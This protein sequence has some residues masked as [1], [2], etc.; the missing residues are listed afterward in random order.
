[1]SSIVHAYLSTTP[2]AILFI[3]FLISANR[4]PAVLRDAIDNDEEIN[5]I[6]L[7]DM[8]HTI[9]GML[10]FYSFLVIYLSFFV[11]RRRAL[12]KKF[13]K[14]DG[15][16]ISV[17]G[18]VLYDRPKGCWKWID[19][20]YHTDLAYVTY[21]Y[22]TDAE[23]DT[24]GNDNGNGNGPLTGCVASESADLS[25]KFVEKK[26]RTY[27]PYHRENVA[28]LV[29]KG[30]PLSGQP[31]QDVERDLASFTSE[32]AVRNRDKIN[33]VIIFCLVWTTFLLSSAFFILNQIMV[34]EESNLQDN[35]DDVGEAW[36]YFWIYTCGIIPVVSIFGNLAQWYLHHRWVTTSGNVVDTLTKGV[37]NKLQTDD[38]RNEEEAER[39]VSMA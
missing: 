37:P 32:Y 20:L 25:E 7:S 23:M 19:K 10:V 3:Y 29:L 14:T 30:M 39:Y 5:L 33:Q 35:A 16:V 21:K 11:K 34:V 17:I 28:V 22:P 9:L 4:R 12:M 31:K 36:T 2:F 27:L 24:D 8:L 26:I 18:N 6:P 1:M 15:S 38:F 13:N